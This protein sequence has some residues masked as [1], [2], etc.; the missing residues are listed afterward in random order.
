MGRYSVRQR[1]GL[2]PLLLLVLA[3]FTG[4]VGAQNRS[5]HESRGVYLGGAVAYHKMTGEFYQL[6]QETS[7]A[8]ALFFETGYRMGGPLRAGFRIFTSVH[9]LNNSQFSADRFR[10]YGL[11]FNGRLLLR[12][13]SRLRPYFLLGYA[14]VGLVAGNDEGYRGFG[15]SF[16]AGI[17]FW[18]HPNLTLLTEIDVR[19]IE[20][21]RLQIGNERRTIAGTNPGSM[22]GFNLLG[23]SW[24]F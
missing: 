5:Y 3:A 4:S 9:D 11:E 16:A 21:D 10:F 13:R 1:R 19:Y 7:D 6:N 17:E 20:F 22:V 23:L 14:G 24:H 8:P 2:A 15:Y 12:W 18:L